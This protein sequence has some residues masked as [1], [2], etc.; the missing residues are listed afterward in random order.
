E[1]RRPR[2]RRADQEDEP[3]LRHSRIPWERAHEP[4]APVTRKP[5]SCQGDDQAHSRRGRARGVCGRQSL[6]GTMTIP[7]RAP[8]VSEMRRPARPVLA[9]LETP[10]AAP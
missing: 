2:A 7:S 10:A 8:G 6:P 4:A 9:Y 3:V 1:K 5:I